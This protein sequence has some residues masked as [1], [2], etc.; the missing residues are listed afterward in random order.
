MKKTLFCALLGFVLMGFYSCEKETVEEPSKIVDVSFDVKFVECGSMTRSAEDEYLNFYN[1]HIKTKE[2]IPTNYNLTIYD[3]QDKIV[4]SLTGKWNL[5][6]FQLPT[7][8]YKVKGSSYG[9][10]TIAE[11]DFD[12]EI[13]IDSS[14]NIVLTAKYGCFLLMFPTAGGASYKYYTSEPGGAYRSYDLPKV[15]DMCYMFVED[16]VTFD[17]VSCNIGEQNFDVKLFNSTFKFQNGYFYY[18]DI[19]SG[20][21]NIPPMSNGGL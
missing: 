17:S 6:S 1:K 18:F 13:N 3:L 10:Y 12:E 21:F 15:E 4:A 20:T 2:L 16:N 7:G 5:T 11:L 9:D 19:V 8:K 14:G